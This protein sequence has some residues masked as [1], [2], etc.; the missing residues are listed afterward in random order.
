MGRDASINWRTGVILMQRVSRPVESC[1]V[2]GAGCPGSRKPDAVERAVHP[3]RFIDGRLCSD[4]Y[5]CSKF[6][7]GRQHIPTRTWISKMAMAML[8]RRLRPPGRADGGE[9]RYLVLDA[10]AMSAPAPFAKGSEVPLPSPTVAGSRATADGQDGL[11][12]CRPGTRTRPSQSMLLPTPMRLLN[13]AWGSLRMT[14]GE[15]RAGGEGEKIIERS[16]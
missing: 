10:T 1:Q 5:I 12:T 2:P 9:N 15:R 11:S 14:T 7:D 6:V 4:P 8:Q 16:L 13:R 3:S